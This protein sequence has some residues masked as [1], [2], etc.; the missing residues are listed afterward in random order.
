MTRYVALIAALLATGCTKQAPQERAISDAE[1]VAA[2]EAAQNR[3]PPLVA[4]NLEPITRADIDRYNLHDK[5]CQ[6]VRAV[7]RGDPLVL[8][9]DGRAMVRVAGDVLPL[10]ADVGG[11]QLGTRAWQYYSGKRFALTLKP[12]GGAPLPSPGE[13]QLRDA[14]GRVVF[15]TTGTLSCAN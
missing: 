9:N 6:L 4:V 11:A 14:W 2:V 12:V 8:V 10:A 3:E 1:A 15:A 7:D 13:L 5:G